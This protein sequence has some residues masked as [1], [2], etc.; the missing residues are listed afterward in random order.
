[1][2]RLEDL[3]PEAAECGV[4]EY[5]VTSNRSEAV[6]KCGLRAFIAQDN[7]VIVLG[8]YHAHV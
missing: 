3:P 1:M 7:T 6:R 4:R 5:F 8:R 2:N